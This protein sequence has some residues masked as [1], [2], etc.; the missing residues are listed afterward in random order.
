MTP[1]E[2]KEFLEHK[3][4]AD[5]A[6]HDRDNYRRECDRLKEENSKLMRVNQEYF[7]RL[8]TA[9]PEPS[10]TDKKDKD[11]DEEKPSKTAR[12][13]VDELIAKKKK[14]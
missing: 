6:E 9:A 1:E 8:T 3:E 11:D 14:R 12:D 4:R 7:M 2:Q 10:L 13:F 5:L